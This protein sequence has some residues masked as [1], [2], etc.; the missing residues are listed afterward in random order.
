M[1]LP[2]PELEASSSRT[3]TALLKRLADVVSLP[4]SRINAFERAMT[5]DLLVDMLRE[6]APAERR[7]VAHRLAGLSEIPAT[8]VRL[9]LRDEVEVAEELLVN[10]KSLSD[11]DLLDCAR[12]GRLEHRRLIALRREVSEVVSD[13]LIEAGEVLV[14]EC[15]LRNEGARFSNAGVE[16]VVAIGR[17][18]AR[19]TRELLRRRELRPAHAYVL[20]WWADADARVLILQR[21]GVSRDILR[22]AT[23]DIFAIATEEG[24]IDELS[25]RALGFIDPRQR[26]RDGLDGR[27]SLEA[28]VEA[29]RGGLTSEVIEEI[30]YLSAVK[31]STAA[32]VFADPGAEPAG[33]LCKAVGLPKKALRTLW[34]GL[35]R[36]A[37]ERGLE[38][39]LVAYDV[40]SV[41]RAQTMLRY[42]DWS[43]TSSLTPA[44]LR[45][46]GE[47]G[48]DVR[49]EY[50]VAKNTPN[51]A[52]TKAFGG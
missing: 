13:G 48:D 23:S 25:A 35:G 16:A 4:G 7:K 28:V 52:F 31:V 36:G 5:A 40:V 21:F 50:S 32:K 11:A 49:E 9:L 45:A 38:Q 26:R 15:L 41:D 46:I 17:G 6:A 37:D 43:M 30:A 47:L 33:I 14:L 34:E 27:P 29:A 39:G 20:F 19:L 42:W 18:D 2:S 24:Q 12:M 22:E 8:L 1:K 44:L 3:R 10:A 51:G